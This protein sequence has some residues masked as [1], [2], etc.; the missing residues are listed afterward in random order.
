MFAVRAFKNAIERRAA[1]EQIGAALGAPSALRP[2][3][4]G[5]R[6]QRGRA[7]AHRAIDNLTFAGTTGGD[8]RGEETDDKV[9]RAAAEISDKIE[10][11]QRPLGR[12]YRGKRP[13]ERDIVDVV[14]GRS[15][16][17]TCL[18]PAGHAA[19]DKL[20]IALKRN[21]GSEAETLHHARSKALEEGVGRGD[22]VEG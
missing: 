14:A 9:E 22:Q 21:I 16:E 12:T 6:H 3:F 7:V 20:R 1:V 17:R 18:A 8:N 4:R 11:R 2:E 19:I 5:H 10:R 15:S 13:D